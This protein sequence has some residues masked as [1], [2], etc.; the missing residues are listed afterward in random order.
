MKHLFRIDRPKKCTNPD[1]AKQ[2]QGSGLLSTIDVPL[3]GVDRRTLDVTIP[4]KGPNVLEK[5]RVRYETET[6][7]VRYKTLYA[8]PSVEDVASGVNVG[9]EA[10]LL[11][12][13]ETGHGELVSRARVNCC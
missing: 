9:P 3:A 5:I 8:G 11:S 1:C 4:E 12:R 2:Q 6:G 13:L 10:C 7:E